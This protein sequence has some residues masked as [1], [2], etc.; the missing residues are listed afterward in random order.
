MGGAAGVPTAGD[1]ERALDE[2]LGTGGEQTGKPRPPQ[3]APGD[4]GEPTGPRVD[5][6]V[7]AAHPVEKLVRAKAVR[8][9]SGE[10]LLDGRFRIKGSGTAADPYEVPF[11]LLMSA[12]NTF[13]PRKGLNRLPERVAFLHGSFVTLSGYVAF[14]ISAGDASELLVMF[15]QWDGCCIGVPPTAYDAVE[16]KLA[17][18]AQGEDRFSVHG[19]VTGR[20]KVDPFIDSNYLLGLYVMED[21]SFSSDRT[22]AKLRSTHNAP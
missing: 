4:L 13:Q 20:F 2:A 5:L 22:D 21:A 16:V 18:A 8:L 1:I 19:R 10:L 15:N 6:A 9:E 7:S 17:R 3:E 12:E 14:P 11:D